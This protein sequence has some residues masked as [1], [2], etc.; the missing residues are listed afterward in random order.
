MSLYHS[1]VFVEGE[2]VSPS[3]RKELSSTKNVVRSDKIAWVDGSEKNCADI[4]YLISTVDT[5]VMNLVRMRGN[6]Q[7]NQRTIGGRTKVIS[8]NTF[9]R[10][11]NCQLVFF[12]S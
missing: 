4:A 12:V 9:S 7:L 6:R 11:I 2:T 3:S 8:K 1:G 10:T 5:I